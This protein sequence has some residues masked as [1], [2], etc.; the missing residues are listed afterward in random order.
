MRTAGAFGVKSW[1]PEIDF[2]AVMDHVRGVIE[3]I[4][5][6]DS[7]QRFEKLGV[8]VLRESAAFVGER[9]LTAGNH[10]IQAKHFVIATG[11]APLVPEMSGLADAPF[12]TNE[13]IFAN[14]TLP[15][16]LVIMG[17][18]PV[19]VEMAQAHIRLGAKATIIERAI[20]LGRED[21]ELVQIVRKQLQSEGVQI[22]EGA[23]ATSVRAEK[24]G[25]TVEAGARTI[26]GSHLL[27]AVGRRPNVN[28]LNL[29]AAGV[30]YDSHGVKVDKRLRTSNKRIYAIGDVTGRRQFTHVAGYHASLVIRNMLF[31]APAANR[32]F[33]APRVTYCDPELAQVG[34]TECEAR[35]RQDNGKIVRATF[36]END[37]AQTERDTHGLIKIVTRKNGAILGASI[38]GRGAGDLI[39]PWALA[40]AKG[41]KI[42]PFADYIAPY[43]T[44]GEIAKRAAG[45]WYAPTL[46]SGPTRRLVSLLSVF[47]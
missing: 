9:R 30:A 14:R 4:A 21:P 3:A 32:D 25:V 17:G 34:L 1:E 28:D 23:T 18:G 44:R 35:V 40:L 46:F 37:R 15:G 26:H 47:D 24:G 7:Q 11:S 41:E 29:E 8:T 19:G 39:H 22:I 6:H 16:H 5:P 13:T 42:K 10:D 12:L 2:A 20:L 36:A 31:K 27:I 33:L 45:A 38:V 43:P